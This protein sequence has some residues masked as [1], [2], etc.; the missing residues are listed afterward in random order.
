MYI[1]CDI[2]TTLQSKFFYIT[3]NIKHVI[4]SYTVFNTTTFIY[5][6]KKTFPCIWSIIVWKLT[7]GKIRQNQSFELEGYYN[8]EIYYLWFYLQ[9]TGVENTW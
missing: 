2:L 1:W 6:L 8:K 9:T 7:N 5:L 3:S 4:S